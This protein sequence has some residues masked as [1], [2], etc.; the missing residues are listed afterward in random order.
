VYLQRQPLSA[1]TGNSIKRYAI[2]NGIDTMEL[3]VS[4]INGSKMQNYVC[5]IKFFPINRLRNYE[6]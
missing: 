3:F 1:H 6:N 5:D 2:D 4:V